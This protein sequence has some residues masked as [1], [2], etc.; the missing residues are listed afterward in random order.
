MTN[1]KSVEEYEILAEHVLA[2]LGY[3]N[4][5][6]NRMQFVTSQQ[7]HI[8]CHSSLQNLETQEK[9]SF[10]GSFIFVMGKER[11]HFAAVSAIS[12]PRMLTSLINSF[13]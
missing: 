12:L 13:I 11:A 2:I 10:A 6:V 9:S 3:A 5:G 1:A 8:S 7:S 4:S